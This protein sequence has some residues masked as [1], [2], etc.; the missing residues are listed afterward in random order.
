MN[1]LAL[2]EKLTDAKAIKNFRNEVDIKQ[3]P[4]YD[5][6]PTPKVFQRAGTIF[7]KPTRTI[8]PI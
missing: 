5:S 6:R 3:V 1:K 8:T 2:K 7:G 4:K